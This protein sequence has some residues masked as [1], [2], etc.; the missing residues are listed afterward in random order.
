[1]HSIPDE[2]NCK[3]SFTVSTT[4]VNSILMCP[5][6]PAFQSSSGEWSGDVNLNDGNLVYNV[7]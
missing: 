4:E 5:L 6:T 1:M 3:S 7:L 2:I